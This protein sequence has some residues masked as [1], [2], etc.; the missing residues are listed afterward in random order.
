[1]NATAAIEENMQVFA[2]CGKQIGIVDHMDGDSIKLKKNFPNSEG[3]HHW[4]PLGW[5]AKVDKHV[6]LLKDSEETTREWK[7]CESECG[8]SLP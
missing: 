3:E 6:H 5:V 1:M 8:T 2:S 4:I 7:S